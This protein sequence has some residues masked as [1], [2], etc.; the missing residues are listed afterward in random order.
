[1]IHN[2]LLRRNRCEREFVYNASGKVLRWCS[3]LGPI[4]RQPTAALKVPETR[5]IKGL[6]IKGRVD[7][8]LG[9][10]GFIPSRSA[11]M[12]PM[13]GGHLMI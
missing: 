12:G 10:Y 1:M 9:R 3:R 8:K 5:D 2:R 4:G 6:R 11:I 13:L 7:S